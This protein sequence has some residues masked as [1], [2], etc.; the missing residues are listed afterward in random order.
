M[1]FQP[2]TSDPVE[3]V[4][5]NPPL[6]WRDLDHFTQGY[7]EA[8]FAAFRAEVADRQYEPLECDDKGW[9][10]SW[11]DDVGARVPG[12]FVWYCSMIGRYGRAEAQ[13]KCDEAN[14]T[15]FG[16]SDLAPETLARIMEDCAAMLSA[17]RAVRLSDEGA[18]L[19][20]KAWEERQA[21][22]WAGF[23]PLTVILSD[24]GKVRF[25]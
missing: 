25:Q 7:V 13:I 24:D 19:G 11:L 14:R 18:D 8:L 12:G 2:T 9:T 4:D 16:F 21:G 23:P 6:I 22:N 17:M 3:T 1:T 15:A 10:I 20:R 5:G